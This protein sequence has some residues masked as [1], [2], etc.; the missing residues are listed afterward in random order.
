MEVFWFM[1]KVFFKKATCFLLILLMTMFSTMVICFAGKY[2]KKDINGRR[3]ECIREYTSSGESC[4]VLRFISKE[5]K[6]YMMNLY[7]A[8]CHSFGGTRKCM[9]DDFFISDFRLLHDYFIDFVYDL[10]VSESKEIYDF[11]CYCADIN[12]III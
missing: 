12:D 3:Q 10:S 1:K 4:K 2:K 6:R 9:K 11:F 7:N 8:W 5:D